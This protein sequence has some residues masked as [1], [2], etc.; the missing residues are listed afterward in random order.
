VKSRLFTSDAV[1]VATAAGLLI[2][3]FLLARRGIL[4]ENTIWFHWLMGAALI[5]CGSWFFLMG[6][7]VLP[8]PWRRVGIIPYP[9][10]GA[11]MIV[12]GIALAFFHFR[13]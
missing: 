2:L 3:S 5:S 10:L 13:F 12:Q 4:I 1:I 8:C 7:G 11:F 9:V 6:C